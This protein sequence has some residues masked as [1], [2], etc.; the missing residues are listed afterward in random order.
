MEI[1]LGCKRWSR[2][3]QYGFR[4]YV[5]DIQRLGT[6]LMHHPSSNNSWGS[7]NEFRDQVIAGNY[8]PAYSRSATISNGKNSINVNATFA[9]HGRTFQGYITAPI[10]TWLMD[11]VTSRMDA[12]LKCEYLV[13]SDRDFILIPSEANVNSVYVELEKKDK[14]GKRKVRKL[15]NKKSQGSFPEQKAIEIGLYFEELEFERLKSEFPNSSYQV[16]HRYPSINSSIHL[17]NQNNISCDIDITTNAGKVVKCVEVKSI[18]M[19]EETP[20]NLTIREWDSRVWCRR[21]RIPYEIVVY[22]HFRYQTIRR[23][24]IEV[25][26]KLKRRPS[27]YFCYLAD[28]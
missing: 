15:I 10:N 19:G 4:I 27:G 26:D 23:V 17:L 22:Y 12:D 5:P 14:I 25:G 11:Y 9:H 16:L 6:I 28:S 13:R 20:F 21:H 8:P 18:S 1:A 2:N 7:F 24:V 3:R